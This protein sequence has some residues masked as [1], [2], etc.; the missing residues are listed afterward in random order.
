MASG[1]SG[2]ARC[3]FFCHEKTPY[4]AEKAHNMSSFKSYRLNRFDI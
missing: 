4:P 1:S 2:F 3:R